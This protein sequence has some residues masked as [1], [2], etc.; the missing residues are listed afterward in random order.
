MSPADCKVL[1]F[2]STSFQSSTNNNNNNAV[3]SNDIQ[4]E[5]VKGLTYPLQTFVGPGHA[6]LDQLNSGK[7]QIQKLFKATL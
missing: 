7:Y 1:S 3:D 4:I 5:Q 2:G 6:Y